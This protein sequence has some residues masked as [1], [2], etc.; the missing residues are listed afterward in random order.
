MLVSPDIDIFAT[1]GSL[2]EAYLRQLLAVCTQSPG[3]RF[4]MWT[5]VENLLENRGLVRK[6]SKHG[7]KN[8]DWYTF[9]TPSPPTEKTAS[10][11][12]C[13]CPRFSPHVSATSLPAGRNL[14]G[15]PIF[16]QVFDDS[17]SNVELAVRIE[18]QQHLEQL[19]AAR[20]TLPLSAL[21]FMPREPLELHHYP[22][23]VTRALIGAPLGAA[24]QSSLDN[25]ACRRL[26]GE[27]IGKPCAVHIAAT[28]QHLLYRNA[29]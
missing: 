1:D 5:A 10:V 15:S 9:S 6:L 28:I 8:G 22:A 27:L 25:A 20:N 7:A 21:W 14:H 17:V 23:P 4:L 11:K 29:G 26:L 24:A 18:T 12:M 2:P 13:T 19:A 3:Y 16:D